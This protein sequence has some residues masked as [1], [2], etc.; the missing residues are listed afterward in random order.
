MT[1]QVCPFQ[2]DE[3][4]LVGAIDFATI[5]EAKM[6]GIEPEQLLPNLIRP[7]KGDLS[8]H[9]NRNP[10][11]CL[12]QMVRLLQV[13]YERVKCPAWS[14]LLHVATDRP[15]TQLTTSHT[16]H[17]TL[18]LQDVRRIRPKPSFYDEYN[19]SEETR[20]NQIPLKKEE[21]NRLDEKFIN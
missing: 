11:T 12:F 8:A 17:C 5:R 4:L 16:S 3:D 2:R 6:H 14:V 9:L 10:Q 19:L 18:C 15:V 20:I 21:L 1:S 7:L 13:R